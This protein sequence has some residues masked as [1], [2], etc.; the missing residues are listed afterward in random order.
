LEKHDGRNALADAGNKTTF[1]K[2]PN[3]HTASHL[4]IEYQTLRSPNIT[5]WS[6]WEGDELLGCGALKELDSKTGEVK[7]VQPV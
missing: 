1:L 2:P 7:S 3:Y 4:E 6:A 5:F